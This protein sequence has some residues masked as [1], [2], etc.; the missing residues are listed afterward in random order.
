MTTS[1]IEATKYNRYR[2]G[3]A[4]LYVVVFTTILLATVTGSFIRIVLRD[5]IGSIQSDAS[6]AAYD[7]AM[8]GV[9]NAKLALLKYHRCLTEGLTGTITTDDVEVNC[10]DVIAVMKDESAASDC[11][12]VQKILG[13]D[14]VVGGEQAIFTKTNI[15]SDEARG[16]NLDQAITCVLITEEEDDYRGALANS[17]PPQSKLVPLRTTSSRTVNY[18]K[19]SWF[20]GGDGENTDN[21]NSGDSN[22]KPA[23]PGDEE[24]NTELLKDIA[25]PLDINVISAVLKPV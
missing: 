11:N 21:A 4:S 10:D 19:I 13:Q 20:D 12:I 3:A 16:E 25:I 18:V 5:T 17:A 23:A 15:S 8:I 24:K 6:Q 22:S 7:A 9:E 1:V 14:Y 2:R